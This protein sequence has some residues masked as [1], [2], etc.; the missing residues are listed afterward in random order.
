MA[1]VPEVEI[2]VRGLREAVV[3]RTFRDVIVLQDAAVRFPS[4]LE[5]STL[6]KGRTVLDAARRAKY[7][8][9]PLTGDLL[10]S[11]HLMLWGH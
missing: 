1:E 2:L 8:L 3:G 6:L 4:I 11:V 7:L 5:F 10:L 9:M